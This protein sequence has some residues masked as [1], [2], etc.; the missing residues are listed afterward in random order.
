[1][2]A[3]DLMYY[4]ET[5]G[6]GTVGT[7]L[8]WDFEPDSPDNIITVLDEEGPTIPEADSLQVDIFGVQIIVRNDNKSTAK[9]ISKAIHKM[10]VGFGGESLINGGDIVSYI[11]INTP[12]TSIGKDDKG[13]NKYSSHYNIRTQSTN[14]S[15]RI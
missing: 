15:Y 9:E 14:D 10:I 1:M 5:K 4:L 13:R 12:P 6:I 3:E 11:T 8:F 7:T 2:I